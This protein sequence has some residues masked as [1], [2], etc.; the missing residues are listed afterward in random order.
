[1]ATQYA[2]SL[3]EDGKIIRANLSF[4][5]PLEIF[6]NGADYDKIDI[7]DTAQAVRDMAEKMGFNIKEMLTDDI[8]QVAKATGYDGVIFR[9]IK[10]GYDDLAHNVFAIVDS[11]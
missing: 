3:A 1:L 8:V 5:N 10:D 11:I 7:S 6:G 4:K 2:D 9:D